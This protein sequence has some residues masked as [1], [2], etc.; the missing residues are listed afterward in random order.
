MGVRGEA[1]EGQAALSGVHSSY[2]LLLIRLVLVPTLYYFGARSTFAA[3]WKDRL[4]VLP[5]GGEMQMARCST[6]LSSL[7]SLLIFSLSSP[8][9]LMNQEN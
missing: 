9:S 5:C 1:G 6:P 3:V 2:S 7:T 4:I 8:P